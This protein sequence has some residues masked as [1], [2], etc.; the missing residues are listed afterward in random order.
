MLLF[1]YALFTMSKLK[2]SV[3][4]DISKE[5]LDVC[6]S[7]IDTAQKVTIKATRKFANQLQGFQELDKWVAKHRE[8]SLPLVYIMEASG[9]YYE[10]LAWHLFNRQQA[11]IVVLA[12][13][14]RQY[15][16]SLGLKSKNDKIDAIGLA[17]MGAEQ[18]LPLWQPM[19]KLFYQLRTLTRELE[20]LH[21]TKTALNN[22]LHAFQYAQFESKSTQKRLLSMIKLIDKQIESIQAEVSCL[23]E[24]D[25]QLKRK[26][27]HIT[28]IKGIGLM[29]AI[30]VIAETNGFALIE[31]QKQLVSYAGYDVV[32]NQSGKR[33]GKSRISKKRQCSYPAH[34]A[35]TG[36]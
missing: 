10:Q 33:V 35:L 17:R 21:Q 34:P 24:S 27:Q 28:Q 13:K 15:A 31:N 30:T 5:R 25:A 3:A 8:P 14:A 18:N 7:I 16:R 9:V 22:Q 11:V 26:L 20:N 12:N 29:S 6:F 32:E 2:Q 23:V 19:S 1:T 4:F 36:F